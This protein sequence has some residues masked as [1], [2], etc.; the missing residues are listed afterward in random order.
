MDFAES[1]EHEMLRDAVAGVAA[2][3]ATTTTRAGTRGT[4]T[5]DELWQAVAELGFLAVHLPEEYGGGGGGM[6]EL[7]IVCEELA[8]AG[9]PAAAHPRLGRPSAPS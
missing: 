1:P 9:L 8:A 4:R 7:A 2:G 6:S 3:S 5:T